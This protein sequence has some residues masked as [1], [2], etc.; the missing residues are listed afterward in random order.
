[1]YI[2][3]P[4]HPIGLQCILHVHRNPSGRYYWIITVP[5]RGFQ[6]MSRHMFVSQT[7]A[8]CDGMGIIGR[9]SRSGRLKELRDRGEL[10]GVVPANGRQVIPYGLDGWGY[11]VASAS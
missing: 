10:T 3:N 7:D 4:K 5:D 11:P 2:E 9:I 1:M 6:M 8:T